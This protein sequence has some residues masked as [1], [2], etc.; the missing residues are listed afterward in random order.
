MVLPDVWMRLGGPRLADGRSCCC[1]RLCPKRNSHKNHLPPYQKWKQPGW[2]MEV[3]GG[4]TLC[5]MVP[6]HKIGPHGTA[7][8]PGPR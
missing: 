1:T 4:S 6:Q 3:N 5:R 7:D 2:A 8:A